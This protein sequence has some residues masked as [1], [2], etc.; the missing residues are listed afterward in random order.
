MSAEF[1]QPWRQTLSPTTTE[2]VIDGAV[3]SVEGIKELIARSLVEKTQTPSEDADSAPSIE[4]IHARNR[5]MDAA[6]KEEIL[7][8]FLAKYGVPPDEVEIVHNGMLW[9]VRKRTGCNARIEADRAFSELTVFFNADVGERMGAHGDQQD[10]STI[11]TAIHFL[12]EYANTRPDRISRGDLVARVTTDLLSLGIPQ[13]VPIV[14]AYEALNRALNDA[15]ESI[16]ALQRTGR[17]GGHDGDE[18]DEHDH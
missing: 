7:T 16:H 3:Y 14:S 11:R 8:A 5:L 2:L 9:H 15:K 10:W 12:T 18:E 1:A 6:A 13:V 4:R 17:P